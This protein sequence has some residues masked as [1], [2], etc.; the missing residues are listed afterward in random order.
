MLT[1]SSVRRQGT[2]HLSVTLARNGQLVASGVAASSG[3]EFLDQ[4]ALA[5]LRK[6]APFPPPPESMANRPLT[7][8]IPFEFR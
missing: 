2:M 6:A 3:S 1:S 7:F 8:S 5:A 4:T